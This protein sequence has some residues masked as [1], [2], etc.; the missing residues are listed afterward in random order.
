[1]KEDV[2]RTLR[3]MGDLLEIT[4]ANA[5][6]VMAFRN[7]A[8]SL[9]D[10]YGDLEETVAAEKLTEIPAIGKGLSKI[11]A[12]LV[13]T[14]SS[15]ELVRVRSLV[16][17]ELPRLLRVRG[18]G[19]KRVRTLWRELGVENPSDLRREA[20]AGR[21]QALRGFGAK[22]V[23]GFLAGLD[24][25][26]NAATRPARSPGLKTRALVPAARAAGRMWAGMSGY[27]Y[28]PWKGAFYP[29]DARPDEFLELYAKRLATVEINNTFYQFPS[30][31][32][33][34][35][36]NSQTPAHFRF[37]LKANRRI[38]HLSR[39]GPAAR[40][41]I[42]DFV[43]RCGQLGAK[44]GCI[45]FQLPPDFAR[46]DAKLDMLLDT[47]PAGPRYAVEFRHASWFADEVLDK[48]CGRNVACVAGDGQHQVEPRVV[49]ADFVYVRLR[50]TY[51]EGELDVWQ[52]WFAEQVGQKRDVLAYLKHDDDG[53][54]PAAWA[55]R[56]GQTKAPAAGE[57]S[58]KKPAK[59]ISRTMKRGRKT[60]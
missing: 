34:G 25:L 35:Q 1:L 17:P 56:F 52:E 41:H 60:G 13:R 33:V 50:G 20:A 24:Y 44:L 47:V 26:E 8:Q 3:E 45:L 23:E 46:D 40:Q 10:W 19:P 31:K 4:D 6:E 29:E 36:W 55:A 15:D 48:L 9:D 21:V 57:P 58:G 27:S 49:T 54:G 5:F 14:G 42:V 53:A 37:A 7:G 30:E 22:T 28:A 12:D 38:T 2:V 51:D 39:L 32:I 43:E 16:P 59:S 18:L 11:I